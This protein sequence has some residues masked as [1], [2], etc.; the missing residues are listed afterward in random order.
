MNEKDELK[1]Q[2]AKHTLKMTKAISKTRLIMKDKGFRELHE[3]AIAYYKD[4]KHFFMKKKYVQS[5]EAL[6][7][8]WAYLD[9]GL[10]LGVFELTDE[11]MKDYFTNE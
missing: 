2:I 9:A 5:F 4:S 10:K 6:M 8:S 7:I 3:S 11:S 1:T